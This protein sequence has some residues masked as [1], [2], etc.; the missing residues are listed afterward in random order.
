[1]DVTLL[2][3]NSLKIRGKHAGLVV[4]PSVKAAGDAV[5][6][7]GEMA[8]DTSKVE[9]QR[10]VVEGAG[11][12]EVSGVKISAFGEKSELAYEITLDGLEI[13]LANTKTLKKTHD[14][15]RECQILI[16]YADSLSDQSLI[17]A[18]SP[19]VVVL[20]GE[21]AQELAK[22]LGKDS[23][24]SSEKKFSITADKLPEEMEVVVLG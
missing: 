20:Y 14:A 21:K 13:F 4:N 7:L 22:G 6:L 17:T 23:S 2:D 8:S 12:Y 19:S 5:L 9:G 24:V 11:E 18:L 3:T 1:M 10:L 16:L 15:K